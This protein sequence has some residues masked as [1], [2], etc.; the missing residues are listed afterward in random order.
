MVMILVSVI[1]DWQD[2]LRSPALRP[3][4]L[5]VP[6][7]HQ[8]HVV[9]HSG[10]GEAPHVEAHKVLLALERHAVGPEVVGQAQ[11][12]A[13]SWREEME[14]RM[15]SFFL[16][17]SHPEQTSLLLPEATAGS[18]RSSNTSSRAAPAIV[19]VSAHHWRREGGGSRHSVTLPA[20]LN[21]LKA[22]DSEDQRAEPPSPYMCVCT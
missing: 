18:S 12:S 4:R 17:D 5:E 7:G 3:A 21:I 6:V 14:T 11:L 10:R 9:V 8:D 15:N 20:F 2:A 13:H 19:R 1:F 16:Q 22:A